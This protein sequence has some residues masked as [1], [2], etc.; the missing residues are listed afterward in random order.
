MVRIKYSTYANPKY[1]GVLNPHMRKSAP[2]DIPVKFARI[3]AK[4]KL[5][6]NCGVPECTMR[7][8]YGYALPSRCWKHKLGNMIDHAHAVCI[9]KNCIGRASFRTRNK[10]L[11][12]CVKHK[13]SAMIR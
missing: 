11:S 12:H 5:P 6:V 4:R 10:K 9:R 13:T 2:V 1:K 7:S 8:T 3:R